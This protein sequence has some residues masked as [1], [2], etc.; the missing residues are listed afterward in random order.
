MVIILVKLINMGPKIMYAHQVNVDLK[1]N[2]FRQ[3]TCYQLF[4]GG[5][6]ITQ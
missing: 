5:Y 3:L 6:N 4:S 1:Q 2:Y